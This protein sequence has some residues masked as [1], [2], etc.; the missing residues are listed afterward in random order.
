MN[1]TEEGLV[2]IVSRIDAFRYDLAFLQF[3]HFLTFPE[4]QRLNLAGCFLIINTE[5]GTT[6]NDPDN[7]DFRLTGNKDDRKFAKDA[8]GNWNEMRNNSLANTVVFDKVLDL[9]ITRLEYEWNLK[10]ERRNSFR[11]IVRL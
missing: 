11:V 1:D 4:T 6:K 3:P 7:V 10:S 8:K 5:R 2:D 9:S